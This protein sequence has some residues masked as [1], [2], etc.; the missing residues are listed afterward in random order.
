L[1]LNINGHQPTLG[2][3][4]EEPTFVA[5]NHVIIVG[6]GV[7]GATIAYELS[8]N[9]AFRITVL[10]RQ[11]PAQ[12]ST[13]AALGVLMGAISQKKKGRAWSMRDASIRRYATLVP[14][15]EAATGMHIPYNQDGIVLLRFEGDEDDEKWRTLATLRQSQGW[16]LDLWDKATLHRRC[17]DVGD[18]LRTPEGDRP[19]IGAVHSV[20]DRQID[21]VALTHALVAAAQRNG[22]EFLFDAAVTTIA[23]TDGAGLASGQAP[24]H[25]EYCCSSRDDTQEVMVTRQSLPA[26]Q[27]V[28]STGLGTFPLTAA[29]LNSALHSPSSTPQPIEKT[30]TS[31]SAPVDI[32]PVAGQ[33][34]RIKLSQPTI[35][36]AFTPVISGND[37]H[38]VPLKAGDY[39]VG[40]TV[41]FPD[42][43]AARAGMQDCAVR[44]ALLETVLKGAYDLFPLLS[45]GT[46]T[47][48]WIGY[49]PRPWNRP[50]PVIETLGHVPN[51]IV[52][53]G[54]YR[55]GVL[56][57][58][59]TAQQVRA[60]IESQYNGQ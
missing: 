37:I 22:V 32:R 4:F 18:V 6:C 14:E 42:E 26:H 35:N 12:A 24:Y 30:S 29:V 47:Q 1:I 25:V 8:L 31:T 9:S 59:A 23:R 2:S 10:D 45:E 7:V 28:I 53:T 38:V 52:A 3:K 13:G 33:A 56:L 39:W 15:L 57:A 58:P 17:P 54:H 43:A 11:L 50:A 48:Q 51:I 49:R 34:V 27:I 40:A 36:T 5:M 44:D 60:L 21:P 55:N 19:I 16:Q 20:H 46:I 41:E